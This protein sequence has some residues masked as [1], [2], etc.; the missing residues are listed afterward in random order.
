MFEALIIANNKDWKERIALLAQLNNK[1]KQEVKPLFKKMGDA[2]LNLAKGII[3]HIIS[4]H[5]HKNNRRNF[6]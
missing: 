5:S 2:I 1:L 3:F 6:L 4:N